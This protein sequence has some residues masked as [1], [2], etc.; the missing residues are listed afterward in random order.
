MKSLKFSLAFS[1]DDYDARKT[2]FLKNELDFAWKK[3]FSEAQKVGEM[4]PLQTNKW[5]L[6]W[7]YPIYSDSSIWSIL[8]NNS[9][10]NIF[11]ETYID[12]FGRIFVCIH[13]IHVIFCLRLY[14][15]IVIFTA[16]TSNH[17]F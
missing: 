1:R 5:V 10:F 16:K 14:H 8:W 9:T 6:T 3:R 12:R 7:L 11:H 2:S 15:V 4:E 13:G 17:Y